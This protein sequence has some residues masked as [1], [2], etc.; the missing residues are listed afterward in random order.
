MLLLTILVSATAL[1]AQPVPSEDDRPALEARLQS[2]NQKT[3]ALYQEG[4]AAKAVPLAEEA[5]ALCRKLYPA[6]Q[7]P[8]GHANLAGSLNAL[9]FLLQACGEVTRAETLYRDALA[10]R[11]KLYPPK[12]FP[13]GNLDL[14]SSL[15]NLGSLL[16]ARG[17]LAGAESFYQGAL[18]MV[19][20][21]YAPER[22]PA[23]HH[24]VATGLNNLGCLLRLRGELAR[25]EP[26]LREALAMRQKLCPPDRFPAGHPDLAK[27]L[28]NLGILLKARGDLVG[29]EPLYRQALA[30][31][32]K[33]YP[34]ERFPAGHPDLA[35]SL[36][37]LGSL[38]NDLGALARAEPLYHGALA[39]RQ[40]VYPPERFPAGHPDLA[41]S[42][43]DMGVLLAGRGEL[44]RAEPYYQGALAMRRKLYPPERFP[45]G[46]PDLAMSLNNMGA[47]F[48]DRDELARAEPFYREGLAMYRKLYPP[49]RFPAGHRDLATCLNNMG[50]LLVERGELRQAE[51]F[52]RDALVMY[53][54]LYPR[55]GF[56]AGHPDLAATLNNLGFLLQESGELARA[57]ACYRDALAMRQKLYPP[58]HFTAGHPNLALSLNNLGGLLH[59]RGEPAR[60]EPLLRQALALQE[61]LLETLLIGTAE[62]EALNHLAQLPRTRDGYLSVSRDLPDS[63]ALGH[64]ALWSSRGALARFLSQRRLAVLAASDPASRDLARRLADKRQALAAL[65][66]TRGTLSADEAER[67]RILGDEKEQLEKDLARCLPAFD[68]L[69]QSARS[70]PQDLRQHL[71]EG[72]VYLDFLRYGR[73]EFDPTQPGPKGQRRTPSYVAFVVCKD[74]P[75]RRVELGLAEPIEKAVRAW[76]AALTGG[77]GN[78]KAE[79][80]KPKLEP[81]DVLQRLVWEPLARHLPAGVH[82]IYLAPDGALTQVPWAA[83]PGRKPDTA[84]LEE[85]ALAV[86]PHGQLL[87]DALS[88]KA[89]PPRENDALLAVGGVAYDEPPAAQVVA[90][91]RLRAASA[92]SKVIWPALPGTAREVQHIVGLAGKHPVTARRGKVASTTQILRDLPDARW[93]H[94]ATHGFFADPSMRSALQLSDKD[95]QRGRLGER[96][97]AGARSPLVLSGLVLAGANI[98]AKDP[99]KE[100]GGILTAEA[101]AG[102]NLDKMELAVLSACETGLG[103][104]AGGEGVFGLQRA[105]H[106][107]GAKNVIASLWKVDDEATAALMR[108]FYHKLWR[109]KL[110]A[111]EALRQAQLTLYRHPERI[112][113]LARQRGPDFDKTARLPPASGAAATRRAPARLWAG[114][115]LSGVGQ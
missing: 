111:L 64:R 43:N 103:E 63:A 74:R 99:E 20:K 4:R 52:Y 14:A 81:P 44:A 55:D 49:D 7:F 107:A 108:L 47:L 66:L 1:R 115:V 97:G 86:V 39:M 61:R 106:I 92:G 96:I 21:L 17:D 101:I 72:V 91:V 58:Q 46:H 48:L 93:A 50:V 32:Q 67:A 51:T 104:V 12:R 23:G 83:L 98:L 71:P 9:G 29:A 22:Y 34:P 31:H 8:A 95:Y 10:M 59:A 30:M 40:K 78:P 54:K 109:E 65:L 53:R 36:S 73:F 35:S 94:L 60:A 45:A 112:T 57:E 79:S 19:Q 80:R 82:T 28:G 88:G 89:R 18:T 13:A 76:R 38:L 90:D 5:V 15:T 41:M 77:G 84:L 2:L 85:Y 113:A 68:K 87:L 33:L 114:F 11:Q 26:L 110:P 27:S 70:S 105:F 102:L 16:E 100:D 25:A 24:D 75:T 56:S 6:E 3:F 62:A 69:L 37:G 42:L